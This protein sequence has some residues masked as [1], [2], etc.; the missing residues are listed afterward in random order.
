[1]SSGGLPIRQVR[2]TYL[3]LAY[4]HMSMPFV[5][6]S[7]LLESPPTNLQVQVHCYNLV[8]SATLELS[9]FEASAL[10]LQTQSW[11]G[12]SPW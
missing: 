10:S 2:P 6:R 3:A 7:K 11:D 5:V 12:S 9:F 8:P 4:F 1:M